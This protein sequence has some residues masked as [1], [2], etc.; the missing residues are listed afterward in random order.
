MS[1]LNMLVT[2][3]D[4]K[5]N[6]NHSTEPKIDKIYKMFNCSQLLFL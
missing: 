4:S 1:L 2:K 6:I 3:K 5:I